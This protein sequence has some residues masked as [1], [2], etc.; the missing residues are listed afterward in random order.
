MG[1]FVRCGKTGLSLLLVLLLP[2][3]G[4][5][6]S[7]QGG[8]GFFYGGQSAWPGFGNVIQ[9]V[10]KTSLEPGNDQ[11]R[12]LG[13]EAYLRRNSWLFGINT[14]AFVN[15]KFQDASSNG[16]IESSASNVHIWVG[17]IAW[18]TKRAKLYPSLGPG[19]GSF[20]VNVR[21]ANDML[22]TYVLNGFAT[23]IALTFDW[24]VLRSTTDPSLYTGPILSIKAGYRLTV[25]SDEWHPA[26]PGAASLSP[27][28]Y[29]PYGFFLTLGIG[30]GSFRHP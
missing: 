14:S 23:D 6:Q 12:M 5:A 4:F 29:A 30:G 21:G 2:Y 1:F 3:A 27:I 15:K 19:L 18:Q 9:Q 20:N 7:I 11:Y 13:V 8:A 28:R 10:S 24:I 25:A 26:T 17:W 22:H 16:V